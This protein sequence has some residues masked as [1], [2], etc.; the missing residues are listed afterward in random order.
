MYDTRFTFITQIRSLL[1][2]LILEVIENKRLSTKEV[3]A[4]FHTRSE[5]LPH[6]SVF[7]NFEC[8]IT[9]LVNSQ[10]LFNV[11]QLFPY[12]WIQD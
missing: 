6:F 4:R 12:H 7:C 2:K 8:N 5:L 9:F 11:Q 3:I 1:L 10:E